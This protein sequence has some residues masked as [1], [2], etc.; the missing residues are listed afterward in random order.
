MYSLRIMKRA[1]DYPEKIKRFFD[2]SGVVNLSMQRVLCVQHKGTKSNNIHW[3]LLFE[4]D[5]KHDTLR[6]KLNDIFNAYSGTGNMSMKTWDGNIKACSYL[7]H[8]DS[9][10]IPFINRG[11]SPEEIQTY[12]DLNNKVQVKLKENSP[13]SHCHAICDICIQHD[14]RFSDHE[15]IARRVYYYYI[16]RGDWMPNKFQV[17]RYV[18]Q[19]QLML[20]AKSPDN[21]NIL[22]HSW[23]QEIFR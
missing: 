4:S 5:Y 1:D 17:L 11:F 22:V 20:G 18:K 2:P 9:N 10:A 16:E 21:L 3:H 13:M 23:V 19:I 14:I 8:E 15:S 6:R 12:R 7:F